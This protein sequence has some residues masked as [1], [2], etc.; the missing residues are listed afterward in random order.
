ML[1]TFNDEKAPVPM[2]EQAVH[3]NLA[4]AL[5]GDVVNHFAKAYAKSTLDKFMSM[6]DTKRA[7]KLAHMGYSSAEINSY[8]KNP[9]WFKNDS[10]VEK[11][12]N[13]I[14]TE[15]IAGSGK[16]GGVYDMTV[17]IL[18]EIKPDLLDNAFL[19]HSTLK[20]AQESLGKL[21]LKGKAFSSSN[22]EKDEHDLIRYFYG[23]FT[24]DYKSHVKLVNGNLVHDFKLKEDLKDLPKIIFVDEA[25]RYDYVKMKLLSE[26]A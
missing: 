22:D 18:N 15:G 25:S 7:E 17:R 12:A 24:E 13:I 11:F 10:A 21:K 19:V 23:N 1:K 26:A 16:S 4:M 5:N 6:D 20:N 3:L 2:Q 8:V 14:L 9:D